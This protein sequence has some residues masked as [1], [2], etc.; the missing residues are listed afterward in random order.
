MNEELNFDSIPELKEKPQEI[1]LSAFTS[2]VRA[3]LLSR[4]GGLLYGNWSPSFVG[5]CIDV[6]NR[7]ISEGSVIRRQR[8]GNC[9]SEFEIWMYEHH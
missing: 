5:A 1:E 2:Y 7:A 3:D 4:Y 8:I 6:T 9:S